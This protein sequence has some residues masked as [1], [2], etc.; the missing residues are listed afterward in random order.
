MTR[1][2]STRTRFA[3]IANLLLAA[4][5]ILTPIIHVHPLTPSGSGRGTVSGIGESSLCALCACG[6]NA[7]IEPVQVP[8]AV[9]FQWTGL[10]SKAGLTPSSIDRDSLGSR[11]PPRF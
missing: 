10:S 2:F 9:D 11:G 6:T 1:P 7:V 3:S 8:L 4:L 5:L